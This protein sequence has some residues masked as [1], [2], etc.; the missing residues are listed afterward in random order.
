MDDR[1]T[2]PSRVWNLRLGHVLNMGQIRRQ[3]TDSA[4]PKT[5]PR[6]KGCVVYVKTKF[7]K[8][9]PGSL[10]KEKTVEYLHLTNTH[11]Q[12]IMTKAKIELISLIIVLIFTYS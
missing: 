5:R 7:G 10:P 8:L 3:I 1:N 6:T 9:Y 4:L 2:D 12:T 11:T